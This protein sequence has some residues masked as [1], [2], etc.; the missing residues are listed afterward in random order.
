MIDIHDTKRKMID[1]QDAKRKNDRHSRYKTK[2]M[3]KIMKYLTKLLHK[4]KI[5]YKLL[6]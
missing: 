1:I 6:T 4:F 3:F 2:K 5:Y